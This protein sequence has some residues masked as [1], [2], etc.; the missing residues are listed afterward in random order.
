MNSQNNRVWSSGRKCDVDPWCLLVQWAKF[1]LHVMVSA[2]VCFGSDGRL[3][4]VPEKVK[5]NVDFY[6]NDLLTKLINGCEWLL[7]NNF[8]FQQDGTLAHLSHLAQE[9]ISIVWSSRRISSH[10]THL[11]SILLTTTSG[12]LCLS[13]TKCSLQSQPSRL[14]TSLCWRQSGKTCHKS[15][16]TWLC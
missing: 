11:T 15:L 5:V 3:H 9:R 4:F 7:P 8:V 16:S 1:S 10:Q 14:N 2:G 12:V 6:M 13:G